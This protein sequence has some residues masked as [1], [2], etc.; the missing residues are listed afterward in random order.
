MRPEPFRWYVDAD[1]YA[2][3]GRT[4]RRRGGA[5]RVYVPD[6]VSPPLHYQFYQLRMAAEQQYM[7]QYGVPDDDD[8]PGIPWDDPRLD[9]PAPKPKKRGKLSANRPFAHL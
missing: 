5:M 4:I 6:E 7:E 9:S 1:G 2:L 8:G 3:D